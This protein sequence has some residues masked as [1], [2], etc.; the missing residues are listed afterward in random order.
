MRDA[1]LRY[2]TL[3]G[4]AARD[5]ALRLTMWSHQLLLGLAL[6]LGVWRRRP[7][8]PSHL[9]LLPPPTAAP[10][11]GTAGDSPGMAPAPD[12]TPAAPAPLALEQLIERSRARY[13]AD[14]RA[15]G[16][17]FARHYAAE[18]AARDARIAALHLRAE[19]V[20]RERDDLAAQVRAYE[21]AQTRLTADLRA[22]GDALG[23]HVAAAER[24]L[25]GVRVAEHG[26]VP[27]A[28][29]ASPA[30][31]VER[32]APHPAQTPPY[33][34]TPAGA[35]AAELRW[36]AEAAAHERDTLAARIRAL[37]PAEAR[38]VADLRAFSA[39]LA[40]TIATTE[41]ARGHRPATAADRQDAAGAHGGGRDRRYIA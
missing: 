3:R 34:D 39:A 1:T 22:L 27:T 31:R 4:T 19:S 25:G 15:L 2:R 23:R 20:E 37:A 26:A 12:A 14:L 36:R 18:L 24:A 13:L 35:P 29:A 6:A 10:T 21:Q 7:G 28:P 38:L 32:D 33:P 30:A 40:R 8:R 5:L 11:A 17:A 16:L 9:H 41:A